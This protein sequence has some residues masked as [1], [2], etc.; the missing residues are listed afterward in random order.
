MV[1]KNCGGTFLEEMKFCPNCG[2]ELLTD[3]N[4]KVDITKKV[5]DSTETVKET[6][7]ISEE[8]K[9]ERITA[10]DLKNTISENEAKKR[11]SGS[12]VL[13]LILGIASIICCCIPNISILLGIAAIALG[14]SALKKN[15]GI[16][17]IAIVGIVLGAIGGII[18]EGFTV[19]IKYI[20]ML[21]QFR[22]L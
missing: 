17:E 16:R 15:E 4:T 6:N 21:N 22:N 10:D 7:N 13:A 5:S 8:G 12:D 20:E 3:E 1:C 14:M 18:G 11:S 2:K 9:Y 19:S